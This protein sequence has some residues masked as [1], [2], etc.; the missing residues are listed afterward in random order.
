MI[1]VPSFEE[2]DERAEQ[3]ALQA[4]AGWL[5]AQPQDVWLMFVKTMNH[6]Y[7]KPVVK[8][9][10]LEN[11]DCDIAIVARLFWDLAPSYWATAHE[12][13]AEG[14]DLIRLI[15]DNLVRGYYQTSELGF[16][17]LETLF[18]AQALAQALVARAEKG[19]P[20]L[21]DFPRVLLGPF[22]GRCPEVT[23]VPE[24]ELKQVNKLIDWIGGGTLYLSNRAWQEAYESNYW[25]RHY[26]QLP[27]LMPATDPA[28]A[29]FS[30]SEHIAAAYGP[31]D[32]FYK[33]RKKLTSDLPFLGRKKQRS[34]L[35]RVRWA[36]RGWRGNRQF[37]KGC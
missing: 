1:Y 16:S 21:P 7:T 17:R 9:V 12:D 18:E 33:A 36:T 4:L 24:A 32:A 35:N 2:D 26:L 28:L 5:K 31:L 27:P 25:I 14:S 29:A 6:D 15:L 34:L 20:P 3:A 19:W 8:S 10:M 11:P 37:D 30:L 23:H 13:W 22:P